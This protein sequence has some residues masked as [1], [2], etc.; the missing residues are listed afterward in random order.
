MEQNNSK[1]PVGTAFAVIAGSD[2]MPD[3]DRWIELGPVWEVSGGWSLEL[4]SE[5]FAWRRNDARRRI[6]VQLRKDGA[7]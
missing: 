5:P 1:K 2:G 4:L 6:V 7:R 3:R